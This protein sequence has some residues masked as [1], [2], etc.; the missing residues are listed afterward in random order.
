MSAKTN[1]LLANLSG[2]I[3]DAL[4]PNPTGFLWLCALEL[5]LLQADF[6][7]EII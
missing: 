3:C 4:L 1:T 7:L 5:V 2:R 6:Q